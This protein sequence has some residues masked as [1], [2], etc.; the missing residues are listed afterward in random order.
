MLE[1]L[2]N[3]ILNMNK[4]HIYHSDIK[5]SNILVL[6][7][8][9]LDINKMKV[10]LID[11]SLTVEYIPFKNNTFPK[12]WRNRP[13]QFNVP[14]SIVLFTDLF[15]KMYLQFYN[16]NKE[17]YTKTGKYINSK[18]TIL[19]EFIKEYLYLWMKERGLGHYKYINKIM[20]MLFKYEILETNEYVDENHLQDNNKMLNFIE[21]HYTLPCIINYLVEI[22]IH[23]I[24]IRKDGSLNV[25]DYLD[26]IFINI[27]DIWGFIISYL[28]IYELLF[29]NYNNLTPDQKEL[30][31]NLKNIF[32]KYLYYPHIHPI[33]IENLE[34]NI[35]T[36]IK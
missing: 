27:I 23:F 22:V 6:N 18:R 1:L 16:Q 7:E 17:N 13:L 36:L 24:K 3:G 26:T 31:L 4:K 14:F 10:R 35:E 20:Y 28:P 21:V 12:N 8:N 9:K 29:L 11:W 19:Y 25:R 32:L 5:A 30:F 15:H 2:N 34:N 33:K